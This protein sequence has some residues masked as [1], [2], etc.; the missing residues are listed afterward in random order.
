[1]SSA[2]RWGRLEGGHLW[3]PRVTNEMSRL[4]PNCSPT[5][6]QAPVA[7]RCSRSS[8]KDRRARVVL[9]GGEWS[10]ADRITWVYRSGTQPTPAR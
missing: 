8:A 10:G 7:D 4:I 6:H 9:A 3:R 5:R 2:F 1:M